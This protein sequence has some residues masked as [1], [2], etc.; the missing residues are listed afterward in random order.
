MNSCSVNE[1]PRHMLNG[2]P[3]HHF[4]PGTRQGAFELVH[5]DAASRAQD[6]ALQLAASTARR[7]S[8]VGA[9]IGGLQSENANST[10]RQSIGNGLGHIGF[11]D[12]TLILDEPRLDEKI[13]SRCQTAR[14]RHDRHQERNRP[15]S[16]HARRQCAELPT[17]KTKTVPVLHTKNSHLRRTHRAFGNISSPRC[18]PTIR[19][20]ES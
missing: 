9:N 13:G 4:V 20:R 6:S 17:I 16:H 11:A 2:T 5:F 8:Q 19:P 1:R 7:L 12:S 10:L 15:G 14:E 18:S 3:R